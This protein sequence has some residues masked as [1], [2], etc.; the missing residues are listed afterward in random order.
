MNSTKVYQ[1]IV[2]GA[3]H[4][5]IEASL[6]AARMGCKTLMLTLNLDHIGQMSCNPAIGGIGKSH[7]FKENDGL[8]GEKGR[9]IDGT[10]IQF[11]TVNKKKRAGGL[12][13]PAP[14][15]KKLFLPPLKKGF[16]KLP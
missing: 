11:P 7:L 13:A 9:G 5:G 4:A 16:G 1:V 2:V 8:R 12:A 10:G 15:D 14:K 3:G 6:A